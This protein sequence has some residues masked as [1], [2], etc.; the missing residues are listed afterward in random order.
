MGN[1]DPKLYFRFCTIANCSTYSEASKKL[2]VSKSSIS[3][4]MINLEKQLKVPLFCK[5]NKGIKLTEDGKKLYEDIHIYVERLNTEENKWN[6]QKIKLGSYSHIIS[7]YLSKPITKAQVDNPNLIVETQNV[8]KRSELSEL[9]IK[10]YVNFIIDNNE[11]A[12]T[13]KGIKR[14]KLK[15]VDNIFIYNK[16]LKIRNMQELQNFKYIIDTKSSTD[17]RMIELLEKH[18]V[19]IHAKTETNA[20]EN[21]IVNTKNDGGISYVIKDTAQS[22]LENK[23]VYEVDVPIELPKTAIVLMYLKGNLRKIDKY[24]IKNYLKQYL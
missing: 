3:K 13:H 5:N 19:S 4:D 8:M 11:N 18:G 20:T 9:L 7:C 23:E 14:E 24:F 2:Y 22:Y 21:K 6:T 16:P 15:E 17:K 1:V 12:I 10:N